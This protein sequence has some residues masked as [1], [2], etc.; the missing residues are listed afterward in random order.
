MRTRW[1]MFLLV[2]VTAAA[3]A[4]QGGDQPQM[5]DERSAAKSYEDLSSTIRKAESE[6][7]QL[8]KDSSG[9]QQ[10]PAGAFYAMRYLGEIRSQKAI[11]VLCDNL[12]YE[13]EVIQYN[14]LVDERQKYPA[15]TALLGIGYPSVRGLLRKVASRETSSK[16][17]HVAMYVLVEVLGK[18][19]VLPEIAYHEAAFSKK[20]TGGTQRLQAFIRDFKKRYHLTEKNDAVLNSSK[21]R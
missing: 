5:W 21:A 20:D 19:R 17:R 12:L 4:V 7:I 8:L 14:E 11:P 1:L 16:Y 10:R 3:L 18:D 6:A 13:Q 9:L 2:A 15:V